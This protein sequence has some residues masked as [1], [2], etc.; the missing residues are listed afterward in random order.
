[1]T[2]YNSLHSGCCQWT[3]KNWKEF[4]VLFSL[5]F[6]DVRSEGL[7]VCV[8]PAMKASENSMKKGGEILLVNR[9]AKNRWTKINRV[10]S[11]WNNKKKVEP[12]QSHRRTPKCIELNLKSEVKSKALY[13]T[14]IMRWI[15]WTKTD[16]LNW[17]I[18]LLLQSAS[19]KFAEVHNSYEP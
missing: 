16:S 8:T 10:E 2:L 15:N 17:N 9:C 4:N 5:S 13:Q 14:K 19:H 18:H 6:R 3:L 1:M 12:K 11:S 7:R